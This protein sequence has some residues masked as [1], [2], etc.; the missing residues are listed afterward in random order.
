MQK[1][2]YEQLMNTLSSIGDG[3]LVAESDGCVV[4]LNPVAEEL[5]GWS[6][7][8]ACGKPFEEVFRLVAPTGTETLENPVR[9]AL[10]RGTTVGLQNGT[11]LLTK[12]GEKR[13]VS[14]NCS[15]IRNA[16]GITEGVVVVFRDIHRIKQME[17]ELRAEKSNLQA[18]FEH[19]PMGMLLVD[20]QAVI[21]QA[22][23]AFLDMFACI[24]PDIMGRRFGD[25]IR[26]VN[27]YENG[28]G[29]GAACHF[30]KARAT[31]N[32]VIQTGVPFNDVIAQY[33][34]CQSGEIV[35][36]WFSINF[37]PLN[38]EG[39]PHVLIV[40][41]DIS[42][43]KKQEDALIRSNRSALK[44]SDYYLR[45]LENFPATI[46]RTDTAGK[47]TFISKSGL[48]YSGEKSEKRLTETWFHYVHPDDCKKYRA[49]YRASAVDFSPFEMEIRCRHNS[50]EYR[51]LHAANR[52]LYGGDGKPDGYIGMGI[53]I[54]D[55]KIA[56]ESIM[57]Y[58]LLSQN[59]RDMILFMAKDGMI[60]DANEAAIKG[61]GYTLEEL[62][63]MNAA[64]LRADHKAASRVME[65]ADKKGIFIET[66]HRRKDGSVFPVEVSAQGVDLSGQ[67]VLVCIIRNVTDRKRA[68]K[69]VLESQRRYHLLFMNMNSPF[70]LHKVVLDPGGNP[71]DF[72]FVQVNGAF[73]K[74][75]KVKSEEIVNRRFS[76][77]FPKT[78]GLVNM[79]RYFEVALTGRSK[80]VDAYFSPVNK[81]WCSVAIYSPEQYH[82]AI[83]FTDIH[84]RKRTDMELEKA[85]EQAEA[86]SKAKSEFLANMSH[87]IRTPLNGITGM[88]DLTLQTELT[89]EQKENLGIAKNCVNSLLKIINDILDFSKMEAGKLIIENIDFDIR[90]LVD[91][92]IKAHTVHANEKNLELTYGFSSNVPPYLVGDPNRIQQVLNNLISNAVK[93]T[94]KGEVVV[95]VKKTA[96][97]EEFVE[98]Q[99]SVADTGIGISGENLNRLFRSFSQVDA[100]FT[101]KFGGTGLGLVISKQLVDRMGGR[102]WVESTEGKG[103][104]FC[105]TIRCRTGSRPA[106]AFSPEP[107]AEKARKTRSILLVE[108]DSVNQIVLS[109]MLQ[110]RGHAIELANNGLEAL[111]AYRGKQYD[112]ILMDIQ[113]PEMDG[114]E[115]TK[116]IREMEGNGRHTPIIALT[117][118]ALQGDRE[119]IMAMGMDEYI[120]KPVGMDALFA[121]IDRVCESGGEAAFS[122]RA[123]LGENGELVFLRD[124]PS[125]SKEELLPI[126]EEVTEYVRILLKETG[127]GDLSA[128]ETT[129][130]KIKELFNEIDAE[131]M[132]GMAFRI[133]L[134]SRRG[135]LQKVME[136]SARLHYEFEIYRK[137]I[138]F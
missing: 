9:L 115:A 126:V 131:E 60:L 47:C 43:R 58:R 105:F 35:E 7:G 8:L 116:R 111:D 66:L 109:R 20:G 98:L 46:W 27:S 72:V 38:I 114:L 33:K 101:R 76:E 53:D 17:D 62:C 132:K 21:K 82:F 70:A 138:H 120:A 40:M 10:E 130:H 108:D 99:F 81:R 13:Y 31:L 16:G 106:D 19:A 136:Y 104:T 93:F 88:I 15:P 102:I 129:A 87:E 122:E 134:D 68:E 54:H 41:V 100:S 73:E 1:Q 128:I 59:A 2:S 74:Y 123:R 94:E 29:N 25:S 32:E 42:A 110:E 34:L 79:E 14:A 71:C 67:Q 4:Y 12:E 52:P 18:T 64:E 125:R 69:A 24:L 137:S 112:V 5:T 92:T 107:E 89:G 113:M 84:D 77:V 23:R 80:Y 49:A 37:V 61:Y 3:I 78:V 44:M 48:D 117:A 57:R 28:C 121:V 22:N 86:A 124:A 103:S 135:N 26:C 55:R 95:S 65:E 118:F 119:R 91:E 97:S 6:S 51:W 39:E 63:S 50:G 30:C 75:F 90:K 85:K 96:G 127:R 133:E 56:E 83:V 11:S 36:P 45:M